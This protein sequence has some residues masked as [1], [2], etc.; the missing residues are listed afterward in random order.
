MGIVVDKTC[1]E[2]EYR[3]IYLQIR[4]QICDGTL[5]ADAKLPKIRELAA[6]LGVARNTVEAAY[7]QL[8]LEGY[9]HGKRGVGYI[10]ESLNLDVLQNPQATEE[11]MAKSLP[12]RPASP[13]GDNYG[14][15]YDFSY[16]NRSAADM[17]VSWWRTFANEALSSGDL[18][19]FATYIDPFGLPG[20]R[21]ELARHIARTRD[22]VCSPEQII[23]QP[24]TQT[25]L[26]S[27]ALMLDPQQRRIAIE[28]PG[29]NSAVALFK[30]YGSDITPIP[31]YKGADAMLAALRE[32][33]ARCFFCTPSNQFPLG[34]I[35]PMATRL[36]ILE[37]A[38]Q[39]GSYVI[40]DDYC[41]EYRYGSGPIPCMQSLDPDHVIYLGTLSK[42]LTPAIRLS[43]VVL[44]PALLDRWNSTHANRFCPSPWLD[45]RILEI[46]MK[47]G[48]W[49]RY[50]RA[51][52]NLYRKRH[53]LLMESVG[54]HLGGRVQ[55]LG[56]NA[57]LHILVGD[58]RGRSQ[59][60]LI[61]RARQNDV[62]VYETSQYW[63][64]ERHPMESFVLVGFSSIQG[65][66]M[67][68]GIRRLG[69]AW[70]GEA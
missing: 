64:T 53:D 10:V 1:R 44:P 58:K 66:L 65:E 19:G 63:A 30:A 29:Y 45:Q 34:F 14:C 28:E 3:Q 16:G 47:K 12:K 70:Y 11:A 13:L 55:V 25:A 61:E 52:V 59:S 43:Y 54:R 69:E 40:E 15:T 39:N 50:S 57:G 35:T 33:R 32:S 18:D 31:V 22:A 46:F 38:Q 36:K 6:H 67:D 9:A 51:T 37:W 20:L 60:E 48:V 27:I 56:A 62:R 42:I 7:R 49:E 26:G 24:G 4:N 21:E 8:S 2:P 17:P 41:C 5:P 23:L 68:E